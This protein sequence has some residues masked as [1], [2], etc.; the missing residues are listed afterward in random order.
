M[1]RFSVRLVAVLVASV[2]TESDISSAGPP[3]CQRGPF[4]A[5]HQSG[6]GSQFVELL[7]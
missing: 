6:S 4:G 1:R 7:R 3:L 5:D 2:V